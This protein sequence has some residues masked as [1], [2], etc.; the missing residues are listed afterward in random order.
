MRSPKATT[1]GIERPVLDSTTQPP[2]MSSTS[3]GCT[4]RYWD[5]YG[6]AADFLVSATFLFET[7]YGNVPASL[8]LPIRG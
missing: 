8:G 4:A 6:H 2:D 3:L 1:W 7:F 5:C